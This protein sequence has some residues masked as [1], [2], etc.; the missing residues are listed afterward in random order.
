M[1]TN[2]LV[3]TTVSQI[4]SGKYVTM[5]MDVSAS[6]GFNALTDTFSQLFY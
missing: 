6:S 1:H 2:I 4:S 5:V 3:P